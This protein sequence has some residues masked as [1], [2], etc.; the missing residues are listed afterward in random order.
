MLLTYLSEYCSLPSLLKIDKAIF[1][2]KL[3]PN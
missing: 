3:T 1:E 2:E